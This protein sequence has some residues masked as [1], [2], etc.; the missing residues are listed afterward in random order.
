MSYIGGAQTLS[1][2]FLN[3]CI[4]LFIIDEIDLRIL[5]FL[6]NQNITAIGLHDRGFHYTYH[7][8]NGSGDQKNINL[9]ISSISSISSLC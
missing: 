6:V 7:R 2:Q 4:F 8:H 5:Y 1:T 9:K 3:I